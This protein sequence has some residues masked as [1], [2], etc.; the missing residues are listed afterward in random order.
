MKVDNFLLLGPWIL[1]V[2]SFFHSSGIDY[3]LLA[4]VAEGQ[5]QEAKQ[6]MT[7]STLALFFLSLSL[8]LSLSSLNHLIY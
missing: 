4:K 3:L 1:L 2:A 6:Q 8:S 5:A 7:G